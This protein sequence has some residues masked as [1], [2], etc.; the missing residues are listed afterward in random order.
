MAIKSKRM[1]TIIVAT[2][3]SVVAENA[4]EYAAAIAK[5]HHAKLIL[6]NSFAL[7][8]HA[9]N[10][11]LPAHSIQHMINDNMDKL[12]V[13]A[14]AL[15]EKYNIEVVP[16]SIFSFIE[17]ELTG[18]FNKHKG[19]VLVLG[20]AA[21]TTEQDL[22]GNTTTSAIRKLKF[23]VLAVPLGAV[24]DGIRKVLFACDELSSVPDHI[25]ARIKDLPATVEAEVE[26]FHVDDTVEELKADDKNLL[27]VNVMNDEMDGIT[28]YYKNVKSNA[29]IKEIA[30]EVIAYKANLLV[31]VPKKHGFWSS[32]VHRSKTR[33][34]AAGLDIPLLSIPL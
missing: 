30:K 28:Y 10:T 23:P 34:M 21:R 15:T 32:I 5:N 8:V 12:T 25:L 22:W 27:S 3:F 1:N 18:L 9:A 11:L 16:E 14:A 6:F 13:R 7:P 33:M 31:M 17:D 4:V 2:D 24:F 26:I 19:D 29:V 20:M